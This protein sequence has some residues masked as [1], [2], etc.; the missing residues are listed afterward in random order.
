MLK[1]INEAYDTTFNDKYFPRVPEGAKII[2]YGKRHFWYEEKRAVLHFVFKDDEEV[3][4]MG[5]DSAPWRELDSVGL[6]REN[7][8]ENKKYWLE[9]YSNDI[10][11]EG[12]ALA[13][14]YLKY[15]YKPED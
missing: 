4:Q 15:E 7:W 9:Q 2:K 6:S 14:D 1:V 10:D 13:A 3:E 12:S 8:K 11:E 5:K